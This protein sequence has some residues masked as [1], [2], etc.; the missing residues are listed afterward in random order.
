MVKP[1]A[2]MGGGM[3]DLSKSLKYFADSLISRYV[4]L[5]L[6]FLARMKK[7]GSR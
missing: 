6:F 4:F 5:G 7:A 2:M 1:R 3:Y